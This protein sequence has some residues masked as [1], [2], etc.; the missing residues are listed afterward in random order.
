MYKW[1][2]QISFSI[3]IDNKKY[4]VH[5]VWNYIYLAA[6]VFKIWLHVQINAHVIFEESLKME[7]VVHSRTGEEY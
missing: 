5:K 2:V 1:Q 3:I 6:I 7:S 4:V